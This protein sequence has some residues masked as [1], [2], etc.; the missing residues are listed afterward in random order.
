MRT[1]VKVGGR[2]TEQMEGRTRPLRPND[3]GSTSLGTGRSSPRKGAII[4]H[5]VH[6]LEN[7]S[8]LLK[9]AADYH[10]EVKVVATG[11]S[12]LHAT[13]KFRDTLTG[14][15]TDVWLTPMMSVD[16]EAFGGTLERRLARGGLPPFFLRFVELVLARSGGMFE[17]T[18][19]AGPCEVSRPTISN[20]RMQMV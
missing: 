16:L 4:G 18:A 14:R 20:Y 19:F 12:T 11:S 7:P 5:E 6:R 15:K 1:D 17:A 2:R 8:E 9:L 10:P 13:A 3:L